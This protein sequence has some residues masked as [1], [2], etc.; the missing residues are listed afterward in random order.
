MNE[1]NTAFWIFAVGSCLIAYDIHGIT[2]SGATLI[3]FS[4]LVFTVD[5]GHHVASDDEVTNE[6]Q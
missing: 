2:Y 1:P 4:F 5:V 6:A 3:F